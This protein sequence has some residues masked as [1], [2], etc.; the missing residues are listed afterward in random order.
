MTIKCGRDHGKCVAW[1][2]G[3]IC[4]VLFLGW[5]EKPKMS[6]KKFRIAS[7]LR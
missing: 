4:D 6:V 3:S 5:L 7:A 1:S 2:N